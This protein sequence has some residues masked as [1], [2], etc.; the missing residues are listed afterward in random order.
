MMTKKE[1]PKKQTPA[2]FIFF[3]PRSQPLSFK[4]TPLNLG[5]SVDSLLRRLALVLLEVL[6]EEPRELV[7]LLVE[8]V[9][10]GGPRLLGV[11]QLR[12]DARARL[13]HLEVEGVVVLVLRLGEVAR[14][15]RVEDGAR[16]LEWAPLAA[17]RRAGADPAGVEEPRVGLVVLDLVRKHAGVAHGVQRKEG[18]AEAG[19]EGGLGL[20]HAVLSAR[21]L[22]RVARDEV[23]HGLAA[24]ELRDGGEDAARVAG[25]EDDVGGVAV[26]DAG[27]LGVGDVLDGVG[28]TSVL[29]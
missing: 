24:V 13:G 15:D 11:E 27:D 28:A 16:V 12:G 2:M 25:E 21:H 14:V 17:G 9:L 8:L 22:G 26:G 4:H 6:L 19:R 1:I 18:L 5:R 7:D 29:R 20:S 23:E 10:A 3:P